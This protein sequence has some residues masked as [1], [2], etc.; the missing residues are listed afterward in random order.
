MTELSD[1]ETAAL[2]LALEDLYGLWEVVWRFRQLYPEAADS[3]LQKWAGDT[4]RYLFEKGFID[5]F[6]MDLPAATRYPLKQKDVE[7]V[8]GS[9]H[10]WAPPSEQ[11]HEYRIGAAERGRRAYRKRTREGGFIG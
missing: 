2:E 9:P 7:R 1:R 11:A 4:I 3:L 5:I 8:L 6:Q 10:V